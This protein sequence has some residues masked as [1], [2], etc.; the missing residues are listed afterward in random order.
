MQ[1]TRPVALRTERFPGS[2]L[3]FFCFV[4]KPFI[5]LTLACACQI[6]YQLQHYVGSVW[7]V[8]LSSGAVS[9]FLPPSSLPLSAPKTE[10]PQSRGRER[11]SELPMWLMN[12]HLLQLRSGD[13]GKSITLPRNVN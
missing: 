8:E 3:L 4:S 13:G 6:F 9:S 5:T 7:Y 12:R 10:Q 2:R 1:V 11:Q